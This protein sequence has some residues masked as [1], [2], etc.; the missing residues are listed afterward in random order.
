MWMI[1]ITIR[2]Q[3]LFPGIQGFLL[4]L[5]L[6]GIRTLRTRQ[7]ES[8]RGVG[9]WLRDWFGRLGKTDTTMTV[10]ERSRKFSI[11]K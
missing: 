11:R 2:E 4:A 8:G 1:I 6:A 9:T 3:V 5:G 10:G 7:A